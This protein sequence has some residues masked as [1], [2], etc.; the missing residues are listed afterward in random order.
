MEY[1]YD[2]DT[3]RLADGRRLRLIGIDTPELDH[4]GSHH[5]ALAGEART[6]LVNLLDAGNHTLSLQFDA[7]RHDHYGRLLAHAFLPDGTN[8]A[9]ALLNAGLATALVVPPNT[10]QLDCY[11]TLESEARATRRGLWGLERYQALDSRNLASAMR[12]FHI[13]QGTVVAIDSTGPNTR[14]ELQGPLV[15]RIARRDYGNFE[16]GYLQQLVGQQVEARGWL[17]PASQGLLMNIRHP[18]ALRPLGPATP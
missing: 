5:A 2:G 10:W 4:R 18:A 11:R 12:G 8:L 1:V 3:V 17:K 7:Q 14:L 9:S 15:L 6:A 16:P 13:V